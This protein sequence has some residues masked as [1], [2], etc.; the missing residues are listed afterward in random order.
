MSDTYRYKTTVAGGLRR[1]ADSTLLHDHVT[2]SV[3]DARRGETAYI[4]CVTSPGAV[5]RFTPG[6]L[7]GP[8]GHP[9][10]PGLDAG[11]ARRAVV[12]EVLDESFAPPTL[13]S[14]AWLSGLDVTIARFDDVALKPPTTSQ[15]TP[16]VRS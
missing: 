12:V 9:G 10:R 6:E 11:R 14:R 3:S 7:L 15:E 13:S 4:R 2:Q 16:H 8:A 1:L 5:V